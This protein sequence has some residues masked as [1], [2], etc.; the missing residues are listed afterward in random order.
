MA[1]SAAIISNATCGE[2]NSEVFCKLDLNGQLPPANQECGI[3]D[4]T[5]QSKAHPIGKAIDGHQG[6]WWQAPSLQF[7]PDYHFVTITVDLKKVF[8]VGY[9]L[10]QAGISPRP[11]NWI[12]ERSLDGVEW[13]PWQFFA[14]SDEECWRAFGVEPRRGKPAYRYDDEV[15]CTSYFSAVD[16]IENGEVCMQ[17]L[18]KIKFNN[19][20]C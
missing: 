16:P 20:L 13:A 3:C 5:E 2:R 19:V 11:G 15:I 17:W 9:I 7:G 4:A 8:Q 1:E 6:T 12:L 18:V 10:M 14:I